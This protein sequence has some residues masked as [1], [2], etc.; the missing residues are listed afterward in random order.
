MDML[1]HRADCRVCHGKNVVKFLSLGQVPLA[2]DFVKEE[3]ISKVKKY[4]LE[5][6]FCRDCSLVQI[7]DIVPADVLFKDYRYLSSVMTTLKEHFEAHAREIVS[8]YN[9]NKNSFLVEIGPNDGVLMKPLQ[10]LGMNVV[11][12][13]PAENIAKIASSKGLKI[14]NDYFTK[15]NASKLVKSHG[16]ADVI[17]ANNV[18]AHIDNIDEIME[19]VSELLKDD[20]VFILEVHYIVDLIEKVQFDTIYHEHLMYYS[21]KALQRLMNRYGMEIVDVKRIPIH[22]G[23][24]SVHA[25][26]INKSNE[27][28]PAVH[29]LMNLESSSGFYSE[30]I[31]FEFADKVKKV[32][33]NLLK[34]IND[35][36]SKN[37][38][39]ICYG[40]PGR[41]TIFLNYLGITR[42]QI[43]YVIDQSPERFGRFVPGVNIPIYPPEVLEKELIPPDY[44]LILA[45]SYEDE[46]INKERKF[47]ARGGRFI[48]PL[49]DIRVIPQN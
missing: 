18:M 35:L 10:E 28:Y 38:R 4:P 7:M 12:F 24:I 36:K 16:K 34:L 13:E 45:W 25:K 27:I 32:K 8:R 11:G 22:S 49:P 1:E 15:N 17:L 23:S 14:I 21:M 48:I 26:K 2:G 46:I 42:K 3:E 41:G 19:G 29:E 31:Y 44:A 9:L 47:I 30:K 43:D 20:G 37:K 6:Y 40:A 39:I 5:V 33:N